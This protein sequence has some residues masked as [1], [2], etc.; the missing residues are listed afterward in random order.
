MADQHGAGAV[1]TTTTLSGAPV[2][3]GPDAPHRLERGAM[4]FERTDE[5]ARMLGDSLDGGA[6]ALAL[7]LLGVHGLSSRRPLRARPQRRTLR[8]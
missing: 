6:Y 1:C 5:R 8:R 2:L 7:S 4:V 3:T